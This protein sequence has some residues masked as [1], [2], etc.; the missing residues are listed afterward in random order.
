MFSPVRQ[1]RKGPHQTRVAPFC[2]PPDSETVSD[3]TALRTGDRVVILDPEN[4]P[5]YGRIDDVSARADV[6]WIDQDHSAGRR[7]FA[8]AE[9]PLVWRLPE[10]RQ[11]TKRRSNRRISGE[12]KKPHQG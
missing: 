2:P 1:S 10:P 8:R 7:L 11:P 3:W 4:R 5:V 6:F 9:Q 12:T